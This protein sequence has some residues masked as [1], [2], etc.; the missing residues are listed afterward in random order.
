M[1]IRPGTTSEI[2]KF[3]LF[4]EDNDGSEIVVVE[5]GGWVVAYAQ[6]NDLG[7]DCHLC[8]ME[9]E[10]KGCGRALIEWL[11]GQ[12]EHIVA[13]NVEKTARGF[14]EKMGFVDAG[15]DGWG[16]FNMEWWEE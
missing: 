8:F 15:R 12:Y 5:D 1:E 4:N 10:Q 7:S 16:G 14:Y 13:V 9:S 2:E 3:Q 11:K 6:Y